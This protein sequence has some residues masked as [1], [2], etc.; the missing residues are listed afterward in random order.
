[1]AEKPYPSPSNLTEQLLNLCWR[2]ATEMRAV[3]NTCK[4]KVSKDDADATYLAIK[5]KAVSASTADSATKATQDASGNVIT[6]TYAKK[7]E[8]PTVMT[9]ATSSTAGKAGTVPAPTAGSQAKYLRADGTWNSPPNTTYTAMKGAT[10]SAAGSAGLVPAP[11]S[12]ANL[13]FLRGDGTW[14]PQTNA[15]WNATSGYGVINNKPTIPSKV[16]ELTNDS[17]YITASASI[18]GG[19]AKLTTARYING[20][21]F[22]GT[23]DT[24]NYGTCG[25]AAAT[26]AKVV[27]CTGF[28]LKTGACIKVKFT[29]TNT[30]TP[31]ADAPITLN[32][33]NTGA[34]NVYYHGSL[35]FS[36]G[37]LSTNRVLEFVYDGSNFH[38]VGDWDTNTK[39]SNMTGA[40][41]SVAGN[42]GLV[43]A[44]AAGA[45]AKFLRG[46]GTWQVP[47]NTTYAKGTYNY[48]GLIKPSKSYTVAATLTT[49]AATNAT[50]PTISAITTTAGRYYAVELDVNG[51]PFVNVP[52]VN[53]NTTYSNMKAATASA[54]GTAG[55]VPAPAAGAQAKYLRGD[56]TWQVP[57]NTTY[58]NMKGASSSAAGTAGLVPAPAAG[59]QAQFLRGD[60]AWA[61][62]SGFLST[63]GGTVSGNLTVTGTLKGATVQATS[64]RNLKEEIKE[65]TPDISSLKAYHY[66]FIGKEGYHVG[67]IAQE[68]QAIMPDAVSKDEKGFLS[69]DYNAVVA[70]LVSKVNDLQIQLNQLKEAK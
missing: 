23:A 50:A 11:A 16:S 59:K 52:W 28:A 21:A 47:T 46:D 69:L 12:G 55:L 26:A 66:K 39:Y 35:I 22:N 67:L 53:T 41:A 25:T 49:A 29:V 4:T 44:P 34:K 17:K 10:A 64:D 60:G 70:A 36:A 20:V 63:S 54:A 24:A 45:N 19:A 6:S 48:L 40:S 65:I 30:V 32:V 37:Y 1:M 15:D 42:A 58:S 43:P 14:Q 62:V 51:V 56:G 3:Y 9:G 18:T 38:A 5:G 31:T 2:L 8:I 68:V 7:T 27:A 33:N 57:T 61:A 13:K